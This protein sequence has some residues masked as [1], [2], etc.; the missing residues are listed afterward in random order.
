MVRGKICLI[1]YQEIYK[2]MK[3]IKAFKN[4]QDSLSNIARD[5]NLVKNGMHYNFDEHTIVTRIFTGQKIF[6]DNRDTSLSPHLILDGE[7]EMEFTNIFRSLIKENSNI[8]DI[9]ANA[10]WFALVGSTQNSKGKT[11][12]IEANPDLVRLINFSF[13]LNGY[14][15]R[16][17]VANVAISG[18]EE[19]LVLKRVK[20]LWG[21]S[22]VG[23]NL[24]EEDIDSKF[25]VRATTVDLICKEY[26]FE[27]V[28]IIKMDIE[29]Y[30]ENAWKGMKETVKNNP[31]LIFCME[32][33]PASY[34]N[35]KNFLDELFKT[36]KFQYGMINN[37]HF[38]RLNDK[39]SVEM[40]VA[41]DGFIMLILSNE[42]I[43]NI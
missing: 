22:S 19:K 1:P 29:G 42:E 26:K 7:W 31:S 37:K 33:S 9:G 25:E 36:F 3:F 18:K 14:S 21:S 40:T 10:G 8:L 2:P 12:A 13:N 38:Q 23:S 17:N 39:E 20:D 15:G 41:I 43:H 35:P 16:S 32:F 28:D 34:E 11:L 24:N 27:K 30:E 4:L 6:V 5:V